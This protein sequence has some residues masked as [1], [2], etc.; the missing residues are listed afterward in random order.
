MNNNWA[1]NNFKEI[2]DDDEKKVEIEEVTED[3]TL[4]IDI[5]PV[6]E[7]PKYKNNLTNKFNNLDDN[8]K[9]AIIKLLIGLVFFIVIIIFLKLSNGSSTETE[10]PSS[11]ITT[12]LPT[13]NA[14]DKTMLN[15][16][17]DNIHTFNYVLTY[18][19]NKKDTIVKYKGL[20]KDKEIIIL[21]TTDSLTNK[22]YINDDKYYLINGDKNSEINSSEIFE[23]FNDKYFNINNVYSYLDKGSLEWKTIYKN[24]TTVENYNIYLEDILLTN[25]TESFISI[26]VDNTETNKLKI[27]VDY[28][29]LFNNLYE[30][31]SSVKLEMIYELV[32]EE[33]VEI[34][35]KEFS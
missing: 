8:K 17:N 31:V 6:I 16:I 25:D 26:I 9:S 11:S 2:D 24:K 3:E 14:I 29:K 5:E 32:T 13:N 15:K 28:S 34:V 19:V 21:K 7:E 35:E 23:N 30:N 27:D 10:K 20:V 22:Y 12:I 33:N 18:N 1:F 4:P